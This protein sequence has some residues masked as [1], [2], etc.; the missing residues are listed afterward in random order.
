M[1]LWGL[2]VAEGAQPAVTAH[3]DDAVDGA[4]SHLSWVWHARMPLSRGCSR[5]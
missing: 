2:G 3:G 1:G 4:T 5:P